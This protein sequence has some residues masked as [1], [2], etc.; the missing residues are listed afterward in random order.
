MYMQSTLQSKKNYVEIVVC[1]C[2]MAQKKQNILRTFL[3]RPV[4]K[5]SIIVTDLINNT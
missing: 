2:R 1:I 3:L 4:S 5:V